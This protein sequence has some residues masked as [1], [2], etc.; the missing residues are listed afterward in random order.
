MCIHV[1]VDDHELFVIRDGAFCT[2]INQEHTRFSWTV[3]SLGRAPSYFDHWT[4]EILRTQNGCMQT[5]VFLCSLFCLP[6]AAAASYKA[7]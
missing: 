1:H 6:T 7:S 4:S 2:L 3:Y 5:A